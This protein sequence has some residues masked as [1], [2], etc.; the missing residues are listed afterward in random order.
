[1]FPVRRLLLSAII[2]AALFWLAGSAHAESAYTNNKVGINAIW[3]YDTRYLNSISQ[4]V[5]SSGGDWGYVSILLRSED[6]KDPARIQRFLDDANRFH[7]IPII[8]LATQQNNMHWI[9]PG[10]NEPANWKEFFSRLQWRLPAIYLVVGNEP[11]LG[12]EWGG[13]VNPREYCLYLKFFIDTFADQRARF[14]ILNAPMDLSNTTGKGMMDDFEYL[15]A[16]RAEIPD[17]FSRIDGWAS[18][19]Y[20][21]YEDKGTRYTYRGYTQEL[22]F[23]GVNLPVFI[24]ESYIGFVDDPQTIATYYEKA[25]NFWMADPRVV[26]ATPHFYNPEARVFW[27]FD[28]DAAGNAINL[29]PTAQR[30]R[31][32]PKSLG[33]PNY[34]ATL[35]GPKVTVGVAS[36]PPTNRVVLDYQIPFGRFYTQANGSPLGTSPYGYGIS[37]D[38]GVP[39]W[40]EYQRLG[41]VDALGYPVSRRFIMD[42]FVTQATQKFVLQWRPELRQAVFVNVFDLLA[43]RGKDEWLYT[44]RQTPRHPGSAADAGESWEWILRRHWQLLEGDQELKRYFVGDSDPLNHY[45][46]PICLQDMGSSVVLRAQRAVFQRWKVDVPWAKAGDITVANGGDLAKEAGILPLEGLILESPSVPLTASN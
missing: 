27:M 43:E 45:G 4:V 15:A 42:G 6:R 5:N 17:I 44:Q 29:S 16:M 36:P 32:M 7:L 30:I 22:D 35:A 3:Y 20:H 26:A 18:N 2:L 11:N 23:I 1:L 8:R 38:M 9:K 21:F 24:T 31:Q 25:F 46:L 33:S 39:L 13:D 19:P 34:I 10:P 28:A 12:Y 14:K 40:N 41:G 37:N